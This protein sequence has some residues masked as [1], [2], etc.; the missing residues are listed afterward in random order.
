MLTIIRW[1]WH[2][3][4]VTELTIE[5]QSRWL[6]PR[7]PNP[8]Q[9]EINRCPGRFRCFICQQL[10]GKKWFG[11]EIAGERVCRFCF[12][13]VDESDIKPIR[14]QRPAMSL[15]VTLAE[16]VWNGLDELLEGEDD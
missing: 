11:G 2:S 6:V 8:T 5:I 12:P 9:G 15:R 3:S 4:G 10:Y 14:K 7:V 1:E 16:D 13:F